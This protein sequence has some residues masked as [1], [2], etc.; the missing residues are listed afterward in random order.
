MLEY[1]EQKYEAAFT[2]QEPY[3]GQFGKNYSMLKVRCS[4]VKADGILV[5]NVWEGG[6]AIYQDNY[7]AYL[8]KEQIEQ[9]FKELAEPVFGACKVFYKIP[10]MVFPI[11][12][13]VDMKIEDF[14]KNSWA[15]VRIYLYIKESPLD[16]KKQVE[17]FCMLLQEKE[18]LAGGLTSW[19]LDGENY[20]KITGD[21][22]TKAAY[23]GYQY[24]TEVIFS[25]KNKN[26][27]AR[28][29]WKE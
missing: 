2:K 14:L 24:E 9:H 4:E 19:A 16:K 11:E 21:N 18:Y 25:L 13:S 20:Q 26:A 12:T 22:F 5:R 15:M 1:M 3:G 28:L 6:K 8:L 27:S 23:A 7:L 29:K 10:E 17:K